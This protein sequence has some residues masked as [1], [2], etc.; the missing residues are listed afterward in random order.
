MENLYTQ[1]PSLTLRPEYQAALL[2]LCVTT[3]TYFD[4]AFAAGRKAAESVMS[5]EQGIVDALV[6]EIKG[7]DEAC[8][9]FSVVIEARDECESESEEADV[10]DVSDESW[11]QVTGDE[12]GV[13]MSSN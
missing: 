12:V 8:Q 9:N 2:D 4:A 6:Q 11:E 3:L 1:N 10:E 7:K 13:D 5:E